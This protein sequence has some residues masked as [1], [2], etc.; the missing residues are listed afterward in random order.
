[1][2][3]EPI[4]NKE[5]ETINRDQ[6]LAELHQMLGALEEFL[7]NGNA[8]VPHYSRYTASYPSFSEGNVANKVWAKTA[9]LDPNNNRSVTDFLILPIQRLPRYRLLLEGMLETYTKLVDLNK[10]TNNAEHRILSVILDRVKTLV[11]DANAASKSWAVAV[12]MR[13]ER[14]LSSNH[15]SD[16]VK[17]AL[18]KLTEGPRPFEEYKKFSNVLFLK[19]QTSKIGR[20]SSK[21]YLAN[22]VYLF[23]DNSMVLTFDENKSNAANNSKSKM[24][25]LRVLSPSSKGRLFVWTDEL[26][27]RNTVSL[28][29]MLMNTRV[30]NLSV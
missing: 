4:S 29:Q 1:M 14:K 23:A 26:K 10:D 17:N 3:L 8:L 22:N 18:R 15:K 20:T 30:Q 19:G 13:R 16:T 9:K 21:Q 12:Q 24:P 25:K 2:R 27:K 6:L 5:Y 11:R 7:D 28:G